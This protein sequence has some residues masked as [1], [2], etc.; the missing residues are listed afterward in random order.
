MRDRLKRLHRFLQRENVFH[1][2]AVILALVLSSSCLLALIEP[3]ITFAD[4]V[5]WSLV[6]LTTVGY[7]DVAPATA[8]GRLIAVVVMFFGIGLLGMLS[9]SLAALLLGRK[10]RENKGMIET[11]AA[12]HIIICEW[13]HRA[14][15]ILKELR[16]DAQT[17]ESPVVLVA[18]IEEKPADDPNLIFVRGPADEENLTRANLKQ[19]KTVIILGDDRAEPTARDAKVVLT[20]LTV[21]SMNP[22]VY[23]VAE[24]ADKANE[25]HCLR[26]NANEIIIGSELSSHLIASAALDHG[27]SRVVAE[28]LSRRDGHELYSMPVPAELTGR[29][30]LDVLVAMKTARN[31]TVIGVQKGPGGSFTAN[32]DAD[33]LV[34]ADDLLLVIAGDRLRG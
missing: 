13:N 3:K 22:A 21:E 33:Y 19:A 12:N 1:L 24:L 30:F 27:L 2:L 25:R 10:M 28:L 18:D 7:G 16:A 5:W 9:A 11:D 17:A 26:A 29:K 4:S 31:A 32:P 8:A 6:T 23:T 15:A 20:A 34:A 14:R